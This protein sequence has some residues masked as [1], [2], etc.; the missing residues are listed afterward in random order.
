MELFNF[1]GEYNPMGK[2][3]TEDLPGIFICKTQDEIEKINTCIRIRIIFN[4]P[5]TLYLSIYL[6]MTR[7][8]SRMKS[9]FGMVTIMLPS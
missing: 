8:K 6:K 9:R 3:P 7:R 4:G 2:R 1:Y 5:I